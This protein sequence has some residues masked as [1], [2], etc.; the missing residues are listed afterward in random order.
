MKKAVTGIWQKINI[1]WQGHIFIYNVAPQ[2][3]KG[4]EKTIR[5]G[6]RLLMKEVVF[7]D[8]KI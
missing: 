1:I 6:N 4:L 8:Y 7:I 3:S 2:Q 5:Y